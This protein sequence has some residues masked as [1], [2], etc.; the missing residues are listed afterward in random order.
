MSSQNKKKEPGKLA[1]WMESK[2]QAL[3]DWY[4]RDENVLRM[5]RFPGT[6]V[7]LM[8]VLIE[9]FKLFTKGRTM[10]RASGVA[11]NFFVALFPLILFFF[12]LIPY[13]PI[14]HLY[15]RVMLILDDFLLPSG[16]MDYVKNTIDGIMNQPHDGLLSLSIILCL[17]F[18]SSGI[19]AIFNGFRNVYANFLSDKGIG[20]KGWLLQR[21]FA[22]LMLIIIGVLLLLS[23]LLISLGGTALKYLVIHEIIVG[24]SFTFF[25]F[26]V[27]RWVIGV[28]AL[29]FG[30]A[31]LYYF[32]NVTFDEHYRIE[33]KRKGPNEQTIYRNFV[34]F[35]PG[36]ILATTLFVLGTVAFNTY[37]SNFSRYN[38]LYGSIGT[39]IIL[40]LWIWIVAILI[41][42]GND[43]NSGIRRNADKLSAGEDNIRRREVVIED[44]KKHIRAYQE[45]NGVQ[46]EKINSAKKTIEEQK[47]LIQNLEEQVRNN[48]LIIKAYIEF[49]ELEQGKAASLYEPKDPSSIRDEKNKV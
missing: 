46:Q 4:N 5:V 20:L 11:F 27:L 36:A 39:L 6:K 49:V 15:D 19:V 34:I 31:L 33:R 41:L 3:K 26:S 23:V 47:A 21:A 18:G 43:L 12:T 7:P 45:A 42:A 25:L 44:L 29:C 14:P 38:V 24:G 40:L 9:F 16:T 1:T 17:V 10:D 13:I 32:G 37:I 2:I 30:I 48:E 28:F 35:S 8:D 22:I